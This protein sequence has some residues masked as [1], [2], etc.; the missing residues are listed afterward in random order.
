M[1]LTVLLQ[2][3]I[4]NPDYIGLI[5]RTNAGFSQPE[6]ALLAEILQQFEFDVVQAQALAQAVLQQSRFD[7]NAL[8]QDDDDEDF[9]GVCPHCINPPMPPL[10]DYQMWRLQRAN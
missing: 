1:N 9:T 7:P 4:S 10:R 6:Q 2:H 5:E 8:H 3:K